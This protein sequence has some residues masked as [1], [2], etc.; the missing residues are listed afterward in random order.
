MQSV[1]SPDEDREGSF[2]LGGW[3]SQFD[4]PTVNELM[5]R[6]TTAAAAML[7]GRKTYQGFA[8]VWPGADETQAA[9]AAMNRMPKYVASRTLTDPTWRNTTVLG[10]DLIGDVQRLR[11]EIQGTIVV[12]G[13]GELVKAL[14]AADLI[15]EFCL[16]VF[17]LIL[18]TG[19]Q[20]FRPGI[21]ATRLALRES[22]STAGGVV[23]STYVRHAEHSS[24]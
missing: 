2:E 22:V 8:Q 15:D 21:P 5:G 18:G 20:L 11:R 13:S 1:L 12:F 3:V 10:P 6:T 14:T 16:L 23:I 4:D 7:L 19:K 24:Q 9:V 17:P